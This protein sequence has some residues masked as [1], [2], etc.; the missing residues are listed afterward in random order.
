MHHLKL[1][2]LLKEL[3]LAPEHQPRVLPLDVEVRLDGDGKVPVGHLGDVGDVHAEDDA[4]GLLDWQVV[5]FY[6]S[7]E[8]G[9]LN[10][11]VMVNTT[12]G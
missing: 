1:F 12:M 6:T 8:H 7:G 2:A 11:I 4:G 5:L 10:L 3:C 9:C